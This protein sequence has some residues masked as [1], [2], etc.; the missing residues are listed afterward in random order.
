MFFELIA[1][2]V[3]GLAAAGGVMLLNKILRGR[4]PRWL[5]PVVAGLTM[6]AT[7]ISSEYSWYDRT[8][9]NMPEGLVVVKKVENR[10]F[11][12]PWTYAFPYVSR[13][14]AVDGPSVRTNS[15][16]E[17]MVMVDIAVFGRWQPVQV[18]PVL[19]DCVGARQAPL[20]A[21]SSDAD[22]TAAETVAQANWSILPREDD[23]YQNVCGGLI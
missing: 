8:A 9:T 12:R 4:L 21:G 16:H 10:V 11:Y 2:F 3:A 18:V 14:M 5:M 23:L 6:I 15:A 19:L 17:G 7:T 1:T 20:L 22:W 13:F